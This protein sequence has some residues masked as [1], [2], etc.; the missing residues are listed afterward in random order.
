LRPHP[1]PL[2]IARLVASAVILAATV[3]L[4]GGLGSSGG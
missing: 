4:I 1:R 3:N 2:T